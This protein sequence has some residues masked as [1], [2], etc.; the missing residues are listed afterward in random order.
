MTSVIADYI[1][2]L[3][4]KAKG[5]I[6]GTARL[7]ITDHGS[8]MLDETGATAS[9]GPADVV[10]IASDEVFRNILSGAQN[11]ITAYMSG[12]LRVEGNVQRALKVSA[13]LTA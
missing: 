3:T 10:L 6:R 13:I 5:Q 4:P 12:K 9:D 2:N 1:A 7:E 11:P 8:V